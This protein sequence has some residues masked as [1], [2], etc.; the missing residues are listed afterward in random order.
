[1]ALEGVKSSTAATTTQ[2][3]EPVRFSFQKET[4]AQQFL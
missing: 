1:M 4:P 2:T 3:G